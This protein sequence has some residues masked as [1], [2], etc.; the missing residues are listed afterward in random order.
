M[1][2]QSAER[3][4]NDLLELYE[5]PTIE[6]MEAAIEEIEEE[7][8]SLEFIE[9]DVV[10]FDEEDSHVQNKR[11]RKAEDPEGVIRQKDLKRGQ[12]V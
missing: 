1:W 6:E 5:E 3:F 11:K 8:G 7:D 9:E 10:D 2:S 4:Q 12:N